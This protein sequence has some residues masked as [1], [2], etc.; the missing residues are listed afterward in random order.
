MMR[1]TFVASIK[2][3]HQVLIDN[4]QPFKAEF[5]G[6]HW[7]EKNTTTVDMEV[8]NVKSVEVILRVLHEAMIDDLYKIEIKDVWEVIQY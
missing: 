4:S 3:S 6:D 8:D 1:G 7:A 2:V 5:S